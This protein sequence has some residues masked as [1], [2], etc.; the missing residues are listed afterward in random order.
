MPWLQVIN[1]S[2]LP[3]HIGQIHIEPKVGTLVKRVQVQVSDSVP[4]DQLMAGP[5]N[6]TMADVVDFFALSN[7]GY[8]LQVKPNEFGWTLD[9]RDKR[10]SSL[11]QVVVGLDAWE[12]GN[13][14]PA[15]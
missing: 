13:V 6:D 1:C 9:I 3:I 11:G 12:G 2:S 10:M 14:H 5:V 4:I 7:N 15:P 8:W